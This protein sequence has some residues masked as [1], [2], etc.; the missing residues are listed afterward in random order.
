[1]SLI[2]NDLAATVRATKRELKAQLPD[3]KKVFAEVEEHMRREVD[4]VVGARERGQAVI[5]SVEFRA[6]RD[7]TVSDAVRQEIRRRGAAVIRNVF[8][9]A[10][11]A[12]WNE[13]I[14]EYLAH[15]RYLEQPVDPS[16]DKYF[17]KLK[18]GRPQIFG[19]YWSKPQ[20]E[21]RQHP[22][23]AAARAFL[24]HLWRH[25]SE[26]AVHF[27]PDRE[28]TYADRIRRREPGD[29]TLGLSPHMDAGSVERW[30]DPNYRHVYRHVFSGNWRAYDPFDGAWRTA[31]EEIP[32]PA[33][34]SVFRTYQGWTALTPQG[35]GD[36]TLQLVPIAKGIM[37]LL[38]RP[39]LEDVPE[40]LLCGAEPGRALSMAADWH[41]TLA[42]ALSPIPLVEPG[43][44]VWWHPDI[45][46]AVEDQ[47]RGK[48]Y[49]NVIYIGAAPYCAKNAEYLVRQKAAFLKGESAPDFA[50]ENYEVRFEGR[51]TPADLTELGKK[52]MGL[53]SW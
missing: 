20:M 9:R 44:T 4:D 18:S 1:M 53:A 2:V 27:D 34:C 49:S 37:Y 22:A 46:H 43:D 51:A 12:A 23:L 38:L 52:Q 33:V 21:A 35:P 31:T 10:Q 36:G 16:L 14:G 47:H 42:P 30:I 19:I 45:V 6:V 5:P 32:S 25:E 41:P 39:L 50:P 7:G 3:V 29:K 24:N 15:N 11:A 13:A 48:G 40:D 8:S 26:G 28:C 17:S